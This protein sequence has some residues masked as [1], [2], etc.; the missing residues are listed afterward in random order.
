M[1]KV[2]YTKVH[3][4]IAE[5]SGDRTMTVRQLYKI[6]GLV[7]RYDIRVDFKKVKTMASANDYIAIALANKKLK[8]RE[9][10]LPF[11]ALLHAFKIKHQKLAKEIFK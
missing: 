1:A 5:I 11:E 2:K 4:T 3:A 6:M 9:K 7:S 10:P 8:E